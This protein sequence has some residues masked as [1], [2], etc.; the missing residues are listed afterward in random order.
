MVRGWRVPRCPPSRRGTVN[1][2]VLRLCHLP[3]PTLGE[4]SAWFTDI[5]CLFILLLWFAIAQN[6]AQTFSGYLWCE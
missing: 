1:L 4:P 6:L 5:S 3:Q 2:D